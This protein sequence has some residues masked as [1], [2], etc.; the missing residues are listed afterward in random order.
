MKKGI[1]LPNEAASPVNPHAARYAKGLESRKQAM[2]VG[3]Q[4]VRI[5]RLDVSPA[6]T[7]DMPPMTGEQL[8]QAQQAQGHNIFGPR[9][10]PLG[11]LNILP[12]DT[13]PPE[14][15]GDDQFQKG[16]GSGLASA[17]PFMARKYGV[18]RNGVRIA[19]QELAGGRKKSGL[20]PQTL[21]GLNA[22]KQYNQNVT[23]SQ[24]NAE[25][26]QAVDEAKRS[27]LG[28]AVETTGG[29]S[30]PLTDDERNRIKESVQSLDAFDFY[31][32]RN[33]LLKDVINNEEQRKLVEGR[34]KPLSL[35]ELV[36]TKYLT[37]DVPINDDLVL[38]F[39]SMT[40]EEELHLRRLTVEEARTVDMDD[41]YRMLR[42]SLMGVALTLHS[43]NKAPLPDYKDANGKF[44]RA[45]FYK[46]FDLVLSYPFHFLSTIAVHAFW[47]DIRVRSLCQ[48]TPLKNG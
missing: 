45:E 6:D 48:A 1:E 31:T 24:N 22:I 33:A 3:G 15:E 34:L 42:W 8:A 18:I 43:I 26:N 10:N 46:K 29:G 44:D 38:K 12:T 35:Y 16:I 23:D 11:E 36:T 27:P 30:A 7:R 9:P 41:E 17:Q 14:A 28:A 39:Q 13:L 2:P 5:P 37:Q 19:P 20:S 25:T 47:F 21:E 4:P 40:G 32:Y